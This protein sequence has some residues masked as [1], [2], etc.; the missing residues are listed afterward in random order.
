ML[1]GLL[2]LLFLLGEIPSNGAG[3]EQLL[4]RPDEWFRSQE[5]KASIGNVLAWQR[6]EGSW[7][8]NID[9]SQPQDDARADRGTFDNGAT[10]GELRL[11]ARAF[12]VTSNRD[13]EKGFLKGF[14]LI[15][16]AQYA[17]GGWPQAYP[18]GSGYQRHVTFNDGTMV[19]LMKFL[20][21]TATK[22]EF[23]FIDDERRDAA[24]A[25]FQRGIQYIVKAQVRADGVLTAW[26]AQHDARTLEPRPA[27]SYELVSL[28]GAESVGI[29]ELLMQLEAPSTQVIAAV[30]AGVAWLEA[31]KITG[32]RQVKVDGDKRLVEDSSAPCLWARFYEIGTNRPFFCGRD[33]VKKYSIAEI[34]AERRNGYAWYGTW[35]NG[36]TR[37]HSAWKRKLGR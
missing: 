12:L 21:D 27:R 19:R 25:A 32:V 26:C 10:I 16:R 17:S 23:R 5:G 7:P 37:K 14:D 3:L 24:A 15:L 6:S 4:E 31:E 33:G 1:R 34:E 20:R 11:L 30:D 13:C 9:S 18:P 2:L 22:P 28:S 35:G 36:L 8:K 29:L